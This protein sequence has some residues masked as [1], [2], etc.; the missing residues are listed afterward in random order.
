MSARTIAMLLGHPASTA[1][2][3]P[4]RPVSDTPIA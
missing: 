3:A 1:T 2:P 4:R